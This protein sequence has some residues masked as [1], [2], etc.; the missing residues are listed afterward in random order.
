MRRFKGWWKATWSSLLLALTV[1]PSADALG[2]IFLPTSFE[3][4]VHD[5]THIVIGNV[6]STAKEPIKGPFGQSYFKR[7]VV[8]EVERVLKG[9]VSPKEIVIDYEV[10]YPTMDVTVLDGQSYLLFLH[11]GRNADSF[12]YLRHDWAV[13]EI[14]GDQLVNHQTFIQQPTQVQMAAFLRAI[15]TERR[16]VAKP[17]ARSFSGI[18]PGDSLQQASRN[19]GIAFLKYI[20]RGDEANWERYYALLPKDRPEH[21]VTLSLYKGRIL[22]LEIYFLRDGTGWP[23]ALRQTELMSG[24]SPLGQ[25][26]DLSFAMGRMWS[27]QNVSVRLEEL[28]FVKANSYPWGAF[29]AYELFITD[30]HVLAQYLKDNLSKQRAR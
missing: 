15:Q 29:D 21:L 2:P 27:D 23:M 22:Y 25:F 17:L 6:R 18:T 3:E 24:G 8:F 12:S 14:V 16:R 4:L 26:G 10:T 13:W 30:K 28:S 5:S 19:S 1:V 11:R 20:H 7:K 9:N